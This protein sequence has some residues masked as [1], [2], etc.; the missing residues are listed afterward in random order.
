MSKLDLQRQVGP[1]PLWAW[2]LAVGGGVGLA[3]V[4]RRSGVLGSSSRSTPAPVVVEPDLPASGRSGAI[5]LPGGTL[6]DDGG[7]ATP[8]TNDEWRAA[9]LRRLTS[10]G[11]G[12]FAVDQALG[13]Y[14]QGLPLTAAQRNIVDRSL[15]VI[16]PP[17]DGAPVSPPDVPVDDPDDPA[18]PPDIKTI[19]RQKLLNHGK[20]THGDAV[21]TS[22]YTAPETEREWL[23]RYGVNTGLPSQREAP[24]FRASIIAAAFAAGGRPA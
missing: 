4:G 21:G 20:K 22:R 23:R 8:S 14:L 17:P 16:G 15:L 13:R 9:A 7:P 5:V 10:E 6:V 1:L 12:A 19:S 3:Y 18:T 24:R 2:L 11:M